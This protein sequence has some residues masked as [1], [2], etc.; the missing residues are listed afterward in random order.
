MAHD[1]DPS[2]VWE[3]QPGG[4]VWRIVDSAEFD[5][6][7]GTVTLSWDGWGNHKDGPGERVFESLDDVYEALEEVGSAELANH[8]PLDGSPVL[9]IDSFGI[10]TSVVDRSPL[11]SFFESRKVPDG[12]QELFRL[13]D[14]FDV[15][16]VETTISDLRTIDAR[17]IST[18]AKRPE[19]LHEL[20]S[21]KFEELLAELFK[22]M[23][24]EVELTPP[25]RDG[26]FDLKAYTKAKHGTL[27]TLVEAKKYKP[28][29]PVGVELVRN[30]Y[31]V[32]EHEKASHGVLATTSRFTKG[33]KDMHAQHAY[34]LSLSGFNE[35]TEWLR[36][37]A[38]RRR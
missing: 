29:R 14:L 37:H 25:A 5:Y 9:N 12:A 19:L 30:L 8:G 11:R 20:D 28:G 35:I 21:R 6:N 16:D 38:A 2:L 31:G 24:Y 22:G 34:R 7:D 4:E 10:V 23:G 15:G 36:E 13:G 32:L 27:L 3:D 18:L 17:L 33:A 26:G 1:D